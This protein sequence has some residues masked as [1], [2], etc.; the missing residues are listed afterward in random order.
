MTAYELAHHPAEG[1][2]LLRDGKSHSRRRWQHRH[3]AQTAMLREAGLHTDHSTPHFDILGDAIDSILELDY[4]P[5]PIPTAFTLERRL[6][7][8]KEIPDVTDQDTAA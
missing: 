6:A 5:R 1:W 8:T 3:A 4:T 7:H 2:R